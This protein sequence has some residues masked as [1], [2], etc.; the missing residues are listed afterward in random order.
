M[1]FIDDRVVHGRDAFEREAPRIDR[2]PAH[3]P[4]SGPR[5]SAS[6]PSEE[7][8]GH[9]T[10]AVAG[11]RRSGAVRRTHGRMITVARRVM[12][13]RSTRLFDC[14]S[15]AHRKLRRG[16]NP[17]GASQWFPVETEPFHA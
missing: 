14:P 9:E 5:R 12:Q 13:A 6:S 10:A 4:V 16:G 17:V 7:R 1:K 11:T 3:H 15:Q 8:T 2:G